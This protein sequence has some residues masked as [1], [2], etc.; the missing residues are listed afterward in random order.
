MEI[1]FDVQ[2]VQDTVALLRKVEPEALVA[3]RKEIQTQPE[4]TAAVSAIKSRIPPVSPL[5]GNEFGYGGMVHNGRTSYRPPTVKVKTPFNTRMR[6]RNEKSIVVI[7]TVS[8][9]GA[10]GFEIIDMVGRGPKGNSA[11]AEGMKSKL[12]GSASRYV[13]KGFEE[14]AKGIEKGLTEILQRYGNK[15]NVKLRVR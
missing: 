6:G 10:V 2:G 9:Q 11:R 7:D 1:A 12:P 8:P 5:Q 4:L 14:R 3:M 13:W 15:V